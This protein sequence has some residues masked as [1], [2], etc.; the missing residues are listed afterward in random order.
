[1]KL[2]IDS[3]QAS[4][5][6]LLLLAVATWRLLRRRR[7][8]NS[9]AGAHPNLPPGPWKLPII[10]SM[11]QL[12]HPLPHRRLRDLAAVHG[13]LMHLQLGEVGKLVVSSPEA[14]R[15]V[16]KTH[17]VNF[18]NRPSLLA[19]KVMCHNSTDVA[20]A[21]YGEYWRQLRRICT[22]ELLSSKQVGSYRP[23]RE[24]ENAEMVRSITSQ[25]HGPSP[26]INLSRTIKSLTNTV[27][28]RAA[29][30]EKLRR[31]EME[32]FLDV[33]RQSLEASGGFSL[34]DLF[35]S[36]TWPHLLSGLEA[37]LLRIRRKLDRIVDKIIANHRARRSIRNR[38]AE[39]GGR[40]D[41][42]RH[43]QQDL[44]DVLLTAQ[45][46][47]LIDFPY[48]DDSLKAV[49][50]DIFTAG[51]D[52][53]SGIVEW[54]MSELL[55]NRGALK[56]AQTEVRR[57]FGK[58]GSVKEECLGEL[59]YLKLV[60]KE[61]MR[62]RP[63]VPLLLPRQNLEHC[64]ID[65]Y[66]IPCNTKVIINA[67]A[68]G[69]DPEYW[70]DPDRFVPERFLDSVVD[71]YGKNLEFIPFG[72]GRRMCPGIAYGMAS[73]ELPLANLLYHFDWKSGDGKSLEN[74]DMSERLGATLKRKHDLCLIPIPY[75]S[76]NPMNE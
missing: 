39:E 32:E 72:A 28:A 26:V 19:F 8:N 51:T 23:I 45:E 1:M 76:D 40:H 35:P 53:S 58:T 25:A 63:P 24:Q 29:F 11:H 16:V 48:A 38:E 62:L 64:K 49:I 2:V 42:H 46:E 20:F 54:V 3:I 75:K 22:L 60:I 70:T 9:A 56:K 73:V 5:L 27:T 52:T 34:P 13:P 67:W 55:R 7:T 12:L 15:H 30:G 33:A 47:G 17:D 18:A 21:P 50:M 74:L 71:Y 10:S 6:T 69:R 37:R 14:A 44:V 41:D 4:F 66:D 65:G 61:V 57:V 36:A 68:M 43:Q 59:K 31:D